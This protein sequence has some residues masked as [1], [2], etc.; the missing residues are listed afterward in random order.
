MQMTSLD[1][2]LPGGGGGGGGLSPSASP[3]GSPEP[4]PS[5]RKSQVAFS[6]VHMAGVNEAGGGAGNR[7]ARGPAWK[8][9]VFAYPGPS[10]LL[11]APRC[12]RVGPPGNAPATLVPAHIQAHQPISS[13]HLAAGACVAP[14]GHEGD[15]GTSLYRGYPDAPTPALAPPP[16]RAAA[17]RVRAPLAAPAAPAT[18]GARRG[19]RWRWIWRARETCPGAGGP[20]ASRPCGPK[21]SLT[22]PCTGPRRRTPLTRYG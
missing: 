1:S 3:G 18:A 13:R 10:T 20:T 2:L 17:L 21:R 12:A 8:D 11:P 5:R 4:S 6:E 22:T 7:C 14:P 15:K 19:P 9:F 16:P